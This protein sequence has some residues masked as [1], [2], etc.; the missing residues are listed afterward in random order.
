MPPI[1]PIRPWRGTVLPAPLTVPATFSS[2]PEP[3]DSFA[4]ET[5]HGFA[6]LFTRFPYQILYFPQLGNRIFSLTE[7]YDYVLLYDD[8]RDILLYDV[9]TEEKL[10]LVEGELAGGFAF[11]ASFDGVA[12]LYFLAT[13]DPTLA[14]ERL[15]FAYAEFAVP[16][17]PPTPKPSPS[18]T[19]SPSPSP[20]AP[21]SASPSPSPSASPSAS[22]SPS[23]GKRETRDFYPL[24]PLS[25]VP[26]GLQKLNAFALQHR[27]LESIR[28]TGDGLLFVFATGDGL[29]GTYEV[30]TD[31]IRL[32]LPIG[33]FSESFGGA[34]G[35][36]FQP[37]FARYVLFLER[38]HRQRFFLL[39]RW[40]GTLEPLPYFESFGKQAILSEGKWM[41]AFRIFFIATFPGES[42]AD[43]PFQRLVS[44][45]LVRRTFEGLMFLN[46]GFEG[47]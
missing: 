23:G 20:S 17:P 30:P 26:V 28:A 44:Y 29:L 19:P 36:R 6:A 4:F 43:P 24:R 42:P 14:A 12:N 10:R 33:V 32:L 3:Y 16:S 13:S 25:G 22:P 37:T 46:L 21:P 18:P 35:P 8:G 15:G 27:A 9:Y 1:P 7:P 41:D 11:K 38:K 45:D 40:T 39:D 31:E 47:L 2:W 5:V 34:L